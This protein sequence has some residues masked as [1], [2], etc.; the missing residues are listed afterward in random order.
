[1]ANDGVC[2]DAVEELEENQ[3]SSL[4]RIV[5]CAESIRQQWLYD[6]R[7]QQIT[8]RGSNN[9]LTA[10]DEVE[11]LFNEP[12]HALQD[13]TVKINVHIAPC[14][15]QKQQKWMLLPMNWK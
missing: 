7:N 6:F 1:M 5:N 4:A 11:K 10:S 14:N 15:G 2:L 3:N 9:C 8:H 12:Q 13:R